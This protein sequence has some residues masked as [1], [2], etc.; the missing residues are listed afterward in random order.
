MP[1][2]PKSQTILADVLSSLKGIDGTAAYHDNVHNRVRMASTSAPNVVSF[3]TIEAIAHDESPL[4]QVGYDTL[5]MY[6]ADL[7]FEVWGWVQNQSETQRDAQRMAMDIRTA[8]EADQ[9]LGGTACDVAWLGT[10]YWLPEDMRGVGVAVVRWK[11]R[12]FV[13]RQD[14]TGGL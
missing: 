2:E 8:L 14:T 12:Y 7:N 4:E 1:A 6:E 13:Q 10:S 9:T 11:A 5:N 3:P